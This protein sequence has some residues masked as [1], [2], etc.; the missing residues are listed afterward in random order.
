[1]DTQRERIMVGVLDVAIRDTCF[2]AALD[3]R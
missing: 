3:V 2:A 1:V